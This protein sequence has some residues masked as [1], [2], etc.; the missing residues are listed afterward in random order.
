MP[1]AHPQLERQFS[2]RPAAR[3]GCGAGRIAGRPASCGLPFRVGHDYVRLPHPPSNRVI[4][5]RSGLPRDTKGSI[6]LLRGEADVVELRF[7]CPLGGAFQDA[8]IV[9]RFEPSPAA[10]PI[11]ESFALDTVPEGG[12]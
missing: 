7:D 5:L 10:N 2:G 3:L 1:P 12:A 9:V 8:E 6:P 11:L 4:R